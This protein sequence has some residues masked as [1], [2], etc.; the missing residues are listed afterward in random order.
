MVGEVRR[1]PCGGPIYTAV[2][3]PDGQYYMAAG[4]TAETTRL[5]DLKTGNQLHEFKGAYALFT[6]DGKQVLTGSYPSQFRLYDVSTGKVIRTFSGLGT[7]WGLRIAPN[8]KWAWSIAGS[9]ILSVWDLENGKEV[10]KF[11]GATDRHKGLFSSDSKGFVFSLDDKPYRTLDLE[12]GQEVRAFENILDKVKRLY[13]FLPGDREVM[14]YSRG[15]PIQFYEVAS[16]KLVRELDLGEDAGFMP[17]SLSADGR[18][19]LTRHQGGTYRLWDLTTGK[20]V[21]CFTMNDAK[22]P[23]SASISPDGRY[24]TGMSDDGTVYLWRLPDPPPPKDKP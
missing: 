21:Y 10:Y 13:R 5:W 9:R 15:T 8:G 20:V 4:G 18:R 17:D 14:G 23:N 2:V 7:L 22:N 12:T 3:S 6:P 16:G 11:S 24:A 1:I 19:F